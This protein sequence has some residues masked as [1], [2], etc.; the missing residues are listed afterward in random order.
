MHNTL[1]VKA[2]PGGRDVQN[3][4]GELGPMTPFAG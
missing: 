3:T 2:L 1:T 4:S